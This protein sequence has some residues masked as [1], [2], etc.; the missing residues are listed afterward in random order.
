MGS[1]SKGLEMPFFFVFSI[2]G[3]AKVSRKSITA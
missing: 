3:T 1:E 2:V